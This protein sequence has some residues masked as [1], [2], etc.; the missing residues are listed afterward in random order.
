MRQMG[1]TKIFPSNHAD[2]I[3]ITAFNLGSSRKG[4]SKKH[5]KILIVGFSFDNAVSGSGSMWTF[6]CA[7]WRISSDRSTH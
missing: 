6:H 7:R 5:E 2:D 1:D 4:E 3:L